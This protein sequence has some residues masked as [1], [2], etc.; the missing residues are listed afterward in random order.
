MTMFSLSKVFT[1]LDI[2]PSG[3]PRKKVFN[4]SQE[5]TKIPQIQYLFSPSFNLLQLK[6]KNTAATQVS[7]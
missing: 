5:E 4:S 2:L 1:A 3:Y 7:L 6:K